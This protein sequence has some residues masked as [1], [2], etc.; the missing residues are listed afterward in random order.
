MVSVLPCRE[1]ASL[2]Q[3]LQ[4]GKDAAA[5]AT[6]GGFCR[7]MKKKKC[8]LFE[9]HLRQAQEFWLLRT[10]VLDIECL[11]SRHSLTHSSRNS[12]YTKQ[13]RLTY[14]PHTKHTL[15]CVVYICSWPNSCHSLPLRDDRSVRRLRLGGV[16]VLRY[17]L[18]M[19]GIGLRQRLLLT[20][21]WYDMF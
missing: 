7:T 1:R 20:G 19:R 2:L 16:D 10:S 21:R 14:P 18:R 12:Q 8:C 5:T 17:R 13:P 11:S 6:H 9:G 3:F 4:Q 15:C